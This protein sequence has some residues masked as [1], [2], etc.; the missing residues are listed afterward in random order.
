MKKAFLLMSTGILFT[1]LGCSGNPRKAASKDAP[2]VVQAATAPVSTSF[3][4]DPA[5]A[6][7][8]PSVRQV[9]QQPWHSDSVKD[10]LGNAIAVKGTSLDGKLDF[11]ILE[12]GKYFFLSFVRHTRWESVHDQ[13]AKGKLMYLRA[14]FE[15]GQEK[16]I[17]WDELGFATENLYSILWSYPAKTNAPIGPVPAR[18]A[19]DSVGGDQLLLQD[20]LKHK[21]MLL[22]V[23]PGV[24]TQFDLTGLAREIEKL[25]TPKTEPVI[26]A[27]QTAE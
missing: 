20:M 27:R 7:P 26:E 6:L 15:D 12:K 16:R 8:V 18:L 14:K 17:E 25:R 22:E 11:V 5:A 19:S 23:E 24:T 13:P 10:R 21:T 9:N 3:V 4:V 2:A 1:I